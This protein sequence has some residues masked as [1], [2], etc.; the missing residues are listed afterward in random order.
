M[1]K[2]MTIIMAVVFVF[3]FNACDILFGKQKEDTDTTEKETLK[4]SKEFWGEWIRMDTGQK[5]YITNNSIKVDNWELSK[6]VSLKRQSNRVIEVTEDSRKYYLYA[7]RTANSSFS[8]KVAGAGSGSKNTSRAASSGLGGINIVISNLNNKAE[9]ITVTTDRAGKFTADEIIAGDEY[10]IKAEGQTTVVLPNTDGD[11]IGT[12]TVTNGVNFKTTIKPKATATDMNR[13]YANLNAYDLNIEIENTGTQDCTAA[14]YSLEFDSDLI[15]QSGASSGILGT[16][17]PGKKKIIELTIA[18]KAIKNEYE[19]KKIGITIDDPISRKSW[20]DSVSIKFHKVL[21]DF[22]VRS[23][24]PV[25]GVIITPNANAYSFKTAG[26]SASLTMPWSTEDYLAVF[27]GAT[28]DTEAVYSLGINII[29]DTNFTDFRDLANYETNNTEARAAPINMQNKIMSYLH[30][31]D[32]DYFK[33]SLGTTAPVIKPVS[34]TAQ[35][36]KDDNGNNDAK[37]NPGETNYL[38]IR[39]RNNTNATITISMTLSTRSNYVTIV[40]GTATIENLMKGYYK[41]LTDANQSY[42]EDSAELQLFYGSSYYYSKSFKFTIAE[43]C[44]VGTQLPFT[45]T[46]T[47]SWGNTWTDTFTIPVQ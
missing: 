46:F 45:V 43:N 20:D 19:F 6:D 9:T 39:V 3:S 21:V 27:S 37:A 8:G 38:D 33:I 40:K 14:V 5:W 7:S 44:P 2:L 4:I 25:S 30:K 1:K 12:I 23:N 16:I 13:L 29:P 32:I 41:T 31:N 34:I 18:C 47:D 28:A 36:I 35:A 24:S 11:D 42:W 17:E 22:N 26:G 10:E 15:V